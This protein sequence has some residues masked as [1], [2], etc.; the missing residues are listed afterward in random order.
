MRETRK[1]LEEKYDLRTYPRTVY[2][3]LGLYKCT[4]F[5]KDGKE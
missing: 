1:R 4:H 2:F 5:I 3:A